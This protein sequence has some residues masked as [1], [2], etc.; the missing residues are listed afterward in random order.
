MFGEFKADIRSF[1]KE[2]KSIIYW[3]VLLY[4]ADKFLFEGKFKVKINEILHRLVGKMDS[5]LD[6]I[7]AVV[8]SDAK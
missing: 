8:K 2:H 3:I 5:K 6:E 4:V 1:I 7:G